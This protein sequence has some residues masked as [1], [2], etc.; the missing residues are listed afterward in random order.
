MWPGEKPKM[1]RPIVPIPDPIPDLILP[2]SIEYERKVHPFRMTNPNAGI[3][4][5]PVR[6]SSRGNSRDGLKDSLTKE[7]QRTGSR[8]GFRG[9]SRPGS[10]SDSQR[11]GGNEI[12][13]QTISPN[14]NISRRITMAMG[15]SMN[16]ALDPHLLSDIE[17]EDEHHDEYSSDPDV[18]K[19]S[20][21]N[22][23]IRLTTAIW[24]P[25]EGR[26]NVDP[27]SVL[28]LGT[29][30]G[31]IRNLGN[32]KTE[33]EKAALDSRLRIAADMKVYKHPLDVVPDVVRDGPR[34]PFHHRFWSAEINDV[35]YDEIPME[36]YDNHWDVLSVDQAS[37]MSSS[38]SG[39]IHTPQG[40]DL[41]NFNAPGHDHGNGEENATGWG[42]V[43]AFGNPMEN[44]SYLHQSQSQLK[45]QGND[46][47]QDSLDTLM[48]GSGGKEDQSITSQ[49]SRT[50]SREGGGDS[51]RVSRSKESHHRGAHVAGH[52]HHHNHHTVHDHGTAAIHKGGR[53][54]RSRGKGKTRKDK[55]KIEKKIPTRD[56]N[57]LVPVKIWSGNA[58]IWNAM[59]KNQLDFLTQNVYEQEFNKFRTGEVRLKKHGG[60]NFGAKEETRQL[61]RMK[62]RMLRGIVEAIEDEEQREKKRVAAEAEARK[63]KDKN[64]VI[65]L[66]KK[67]EEER[68]K[69]RTYIRTMKH[70]NEIVM[71][72]RLQSNGYLW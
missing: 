41:I 42:R 7:I 32:N 25:V 70:D 67:H 19:E 26:L 63:K 34:N 62:V 50:G 14:R 56:P 24:N 18:V 53:Q 57:S 66:K 38:I 43:D 4:A 61:A 65:Q 44:P 40:H 15:E 1:E 55:G 45:I 30:A 47:I 51:H 9:G 60:G 10:M 54:G 46:L 28:R 48:T 68:H 2:G 36:E 16:T 27:T 69:H 59:E 49:S 37:Q 64:K 35:D 11:A 58:V 8:Q 21:S 3:P 23:T 72:Q 20:M 17:D 29:G 5:V 39:S 52:H 22:K 12:N 13:T 6:V 31:D 71:T 33:K